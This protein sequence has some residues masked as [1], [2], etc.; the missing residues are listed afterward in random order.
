MKQ[1]KKNDI[2]ALLDYAGSHR[3]LTFLGLALSAVYHCL[4][5]NLV[6]HFISKNHT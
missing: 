1:K 6:R 2:A 4:F 5:I 3:G